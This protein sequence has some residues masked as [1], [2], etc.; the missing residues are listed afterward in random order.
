MTRVA[1]TRSA[2][3]LDWAASGVDTTGHLVLGFLVGLMAIANDPVNY[4][5]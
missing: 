4:Y 5:R 3:L 1:S 2:K